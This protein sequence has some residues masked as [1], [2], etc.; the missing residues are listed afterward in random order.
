MT[1]NPIP[2]S[3]YP[4]RAKRPFNSKMSKEKLVN[5]GFTMLP[6]WHDAVDRYNQELIKVRKKER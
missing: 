3:E 6:D 4:T 1:V 2:S 5:D